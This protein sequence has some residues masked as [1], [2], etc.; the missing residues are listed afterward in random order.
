[1]DQQAVSELAP[2]G[3]L[4]A[5]INMS[6]FLLV[7]GQGAN[8]EPAGVSPDMAQAIADK[9]NV[10][11][12]LLPFKGPGEVADAALTGEWDIANIA[13]EP[14]RAKQINFSPAYCEIQATYLLP[15]NSALRSVNDVD[16]AG[17]NIA[18]KGRA[19]YDLWLSENLN[20]ATLHRAPSIDASFD[21][22][23]EKKL[24]A[25]AGLRP[26]LIEDAQRLPDSILLDES[27]TAVQ[28]CIGCLPNLPA[29]SGFLD[30]FVRE[31]IES[32]FVAS[33]L[34]KHNVAGKLSVAPLA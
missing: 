17:V 18:V 29:A 26:R 5:G 14:E 25:L 16:A 24:D 10:P 27:F 21:L 3:V 19:A 13:A 20:H 2:S 1:M 28:Q 32:G 8:G 9:L 12:Q 11:L 7:N 34:E 33:L 22:F 4:R 30:Q 31:A 23:V 6:N 15:A